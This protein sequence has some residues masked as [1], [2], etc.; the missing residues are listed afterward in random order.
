MSRQHETLREIVLAQGR[1]SA[2]YI[3]VG[4]THIMPCC[5][6]SNS[7]YGAMKSLSDEVIGGEQSGGSQSG[8][9][10]APRRGAGRRFRRCE[11]S[12]GSECTSWCSTGNEKSRYPQPG[13]TQGLTAG[14]TGDEEERRGDEVR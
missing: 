5:P 13:G 1:D 7:T 2:G 11:V 9:E 10:R 6:A 4:G 12:Y 3:R 8:A 14:V